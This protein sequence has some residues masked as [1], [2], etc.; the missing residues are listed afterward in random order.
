MT[1]AEPVLHPLEHSLF[2]FSLF[3]GSFHHL[4]AQLHVAET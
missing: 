4:S 1:R 2:G 3:Y